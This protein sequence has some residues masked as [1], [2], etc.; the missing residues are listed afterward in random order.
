MQSTWMFCHNNTNV[1]SVQEF[2][3]CYDSMIFKK[4]EMIFGSY[5]W[6]YI[7]WKSPDLH[8]QWDELSYSMMYGKCQLARDIGE[9]EETKFVKL[10]L[11]DSLEY[12]VWIHDPNF[13]FMSW[14]PRSTPSLLAKLKFNK[15]DRNHLIQYISKEKNI[16]LNTEKAKIVQIIHSSF[17]H[18][19]AIH[20][21]HIFMK[22][23]FWFSNWSWTMIQ[24]H[25][26]QNTKKHLSRNVSYL[27]LT[28]LRDARYQNSFFFC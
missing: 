14:N 20:H 16:L 5:H 12:R 4:D 22:S 26:V 27:T 15:I 10:K 24:S 28:T 6:D 9:I 17:N 2:Y 19:S 8:I 3:K 1:T 18:K 25:P 21:D 13:F 7:N 11:N 23:I